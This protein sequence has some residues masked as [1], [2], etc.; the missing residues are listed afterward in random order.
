MGFST[1]T[2]L[3]HLEVVP[4]LDYC[5]GIWGYQRTGQIDTI[6]YRAIH[7]YLGEHKFAPN[8]HMNSERLTK[9][10]FIGILI[11]D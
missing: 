7:F 2:T 5:S 6:Q 11:E 9:N 1:F 4:I 8:L 10:V 3:F